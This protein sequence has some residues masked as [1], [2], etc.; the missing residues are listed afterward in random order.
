MKLEAK[1]RLLSFNTQDVV[2]GVR[3]LQNTLNALAGKLEK[4]DT[5]MSKKVTERE[6]LTSADVEHILETSE[7]Y[8]KDISAEGAA[9]LK[10][11]KAVK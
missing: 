2:S 9:L 10:A 5:K 3:K 1:Q 6:E 4:F 11:L 7:D 8:L